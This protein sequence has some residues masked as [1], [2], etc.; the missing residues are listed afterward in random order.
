MFDVKD[1]NSLVNTASND[2][3][4]GF[5]SCDIDCMMNCF[6]NWFIM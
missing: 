6:D 2:E 4:L 5:S 3:E 1:T